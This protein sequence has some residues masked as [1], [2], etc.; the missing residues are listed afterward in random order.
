[1]KKFTP[2]LITWKDS[3]GSAEWLEQRDITHE[4]N[5]VIEVGLFFKKDRTG[6]TT[7]K[8]HDKTSGC[9]HG[10]SFIPAANVIS[11]APLA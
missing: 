8:A 4:P 3:N 2:V 7:V 10:V 1:M 11:I 6:I 5:T 9:V